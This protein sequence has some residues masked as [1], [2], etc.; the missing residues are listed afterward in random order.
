[1]NRTL[2]LTREGLR[3]L[4]FT[5]GELPYQLTE[6]LEGTAGGREVS[7]PRGPYSLDGDRFADFLTLPAPTPQAQCDRTVSLLAAAVHYHLP[8]ALSSSGEELFRNILT[9]GETD[10]SVLDY[11]ARR[12]AAEYLAMQEGAVSLCYTD[13]TAGREGFYLSEASLKC[14]RAAF[15]A[16][17]AEAA[18]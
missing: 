7:Y 18:G 6:D 1:M 13:G 17:E 14:L 11:R 16:M 4:A 12:E 15:G 10:L 9:E 5:A 8:A 3:N 2:A